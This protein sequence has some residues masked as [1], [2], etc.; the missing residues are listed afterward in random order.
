MIIELNF[1]QLFIQSSRTKYQHATGMY[2]KTYR[3]ID[4]HQRLYNTI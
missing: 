2:I 3:D 4:A 1:Q